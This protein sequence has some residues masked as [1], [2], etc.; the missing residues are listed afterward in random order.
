V[1]ASVLIDIVFARPGTPSTSRWPRARRQT[2][3]RSRST[4]WPTIVRFTW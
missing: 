4:S 3:M 2:A 1:A